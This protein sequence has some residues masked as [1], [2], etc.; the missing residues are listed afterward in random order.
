MEL[1]LFIN[2]HSKKTRLIARLCVTTVSS[3]LDVDTEQLEG[4]DYNGSTWEAVTKDFE[5]VRDNK[6]KAQ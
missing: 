4:R 1:Y 2:S 6:D 5:A 3:H